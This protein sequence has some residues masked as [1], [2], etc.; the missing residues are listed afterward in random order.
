M[1]D[2]AEASIV[3]ELDPDLRQRYEEMGGIFLPCLL[4]IQ[5]VRTAQEEATRSRV[6]NALY[7]NVSVDL[8]A[9][10][11][12]QLQAIYLE[13]FNVIEQTSATVVNSRTRY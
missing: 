2:L 6:L 3:K 9:L 12:Q 7:G 8:K 5:S 4:S 10:S 11:K 1:E 13:P